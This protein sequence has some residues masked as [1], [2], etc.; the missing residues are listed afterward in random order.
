[1][2]NCTPNDRGLSTCHSAKPGTLGWPGPCFAR[3]PMDRGAKAYSPVSMSI[4]LTYTTL[5]SVAAGV[6][7]AA[8]ALI[9]I[10]ATPAVDEGEG[11]C[12]L[13]V[14]GLFAAGTALA[15]AGASGLGTARSL[16]LARP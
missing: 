11:A 3:S 1:M 14:N 4:P 12:M 7:A 5:V 10:F 15:W 13:S 16:S 6:A 8:P 2:P 9:A